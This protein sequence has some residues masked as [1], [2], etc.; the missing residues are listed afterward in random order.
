MRSS[1]LDSARLQYGRP[2]PSRSS[3]SKRTTVFSLPVSSIP[4]AL[5]IFLVLLTAWS[6]S[7]LAPRLRAALHSVGTFSANADAGT[8]D[9]TFLPQSSSV[10][11]IQLATIFTPQV[12]FWSED[13]LKWAHEYELDPNIIALVMQI[14]S[15][16]YP[17]AHSQAGAR[18]LFQVMPFHFGH[19]E[20]PYDPATNARRGLSYLVRSL[21]LAEGKLDLALAGYNGGH[22][23]IQTS[24]SLWPE[25]TQRYV[26]WGGHIY[27]E[28]GNDESISPTLQEWLDTGGERLCERAAA[29]QA[30]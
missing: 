22:Q 29:A 30:E 24:P 20:D 12:L 7:I 26:Y 19:D 5:A 3:T 28:I 13:I 25:E 9:S 4:I 6:F 15:C 14:E 1:S 8:P 21:E 2:L 18:G 27:N 23:M 17:Q 10:D 16:G 11:S